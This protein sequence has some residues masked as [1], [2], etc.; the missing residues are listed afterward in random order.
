M[1]TF[2]LPDGARLHVE[3]RGGAGAPV[4]LAHGVLSSSEV[5]RAVAD[6]LE[7]AGR[8]VVLVDDRGHGGSSP[9]VA[10]FSP[11][12]AADDL[13]AF[14][15]AEH[16]TG[17]HLVGHSRGGTAIS[18]LAV[19]A[20]HLVRSLSLVASPPQATEVFR[21][22]FRKRLEALAPDAPDVTR[23]ALAYLAR[24]PDDDF[25]AQALRRLDVPA[26]VVEP[27]DDPLYSPVGTMFWRL[28]LPYADM[29][30]PDGG[31]A[32]FER[33][34]GASWLAERLLRHV[35]SAEKR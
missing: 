21:A 17:A 34:P 2:T 19:E 18:W 3:R 27:S 33:E 16:P 10:D 26:L 25:P 5:W 11:Q 9:E 13:R 14:L 23:R 12:A 22:T 8:G 20:P 32:F 4:V 24:I 15:E 1:A 28:F 6:L 30:R 35:E 7:A 31:H 29:E